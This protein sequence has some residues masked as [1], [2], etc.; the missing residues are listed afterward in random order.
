MTALTKLYNVESYLCDQYERAE[1]GTAD[2]YWYFDAFIAIEK[3][4]DA[5]V[6]EV[7]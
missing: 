7:M 6:L 4:L 1:P 3:F 5:V 2:Y